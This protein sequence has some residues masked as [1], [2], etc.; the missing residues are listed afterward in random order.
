MMRFSKFAAAALVAAAG[1]STANAVVVVTNTTQQNAVF[2]V[3]SSDLLQ[4][5]LAGVASSGSFIREGEQGLVALNDGGFGAL[6]SVITSGPG[7]AAATADGSNSITYA[8]NG[9]YNLTSISSYA[10]WDQYRG[11][12]SYTVSLAYA[13]APS[14]FVTL[15]TVYNNAI[16]S[17]ST[18]A[19]NTLATI[20]RSAGFLAGGVVAI[21]FDFASDLQ[22]GYAG[23]RELD[24][25]GSA[26]PEPGTWLMLLAG[27]GMVGASMRRRKLA[28]AN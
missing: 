12:Q 6:G 3:S 7:L 28:A 4:T 10:G 9:V 13:G 18:D 21:R 25:A 20:N 26:I 11:G 1:A 2:S 24:V 22:F 23:Y 14:T 17:G 15:A 5:S 8:L 19:L 16:G 27:F